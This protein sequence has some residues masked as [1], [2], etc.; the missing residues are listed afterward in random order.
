M[1]TEKLVESLQKKGYIPHV[2]EN[3]DEAKAYL[4]SEIHDTTVGIGGSMTVQEMG[5]YESLCENNRV[6]LHWKE[7]GQETVRAAAFSDVY[8]LSANGVAE[9][10]EIV[11]IDGTGN[12]VAA[13]VIGHNRVYMIIGENKIVPTREEAYDRA[14]NIAAPLNARRLSRKTPCA[15]GDEVRCFDCSSPE[16]I[17]NAC[18]IFERKPNGIPEYHIVLVKEKLGY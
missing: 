18:M 1:I 10:G 5:L 3:K 7:K 9:T 2:F 4:L 14:R 13:S 15:T 8:I 17:C 12:R 11:N 6:Y 16:R